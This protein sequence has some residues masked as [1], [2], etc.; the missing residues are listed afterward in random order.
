ML[1]ETEK[2]PKYSTILVAVLIVIDIFFSVVYA[3]NTLTEFLGVIG[4]VALVI[5]SVLFACL[6]ILT[7]SL[8]IFFMFVPSFAIPLSISGEMTIAFIGL[9]YIPLGFMLS[10]GIRQ[11][12]SRS[13]ILVRLSSII[14]IFYIILLFFMFVFSMGNFS[15]NNIKEIID[16]ETTEFIDYYNEVVSLYEISEQ[17]APM[18]ETERNA[19]IESLKAIIPSIIIIYV[20]IISFFATS[21]FRILYNAFVVKVQF[22]RAVIKRDKIQKEDWKI[23]MSLIST[24]VFIV[25]ILF[26]MFSSNNIWIIIA[27][28]NIIYILTPGLFIVGFYFIHGKIKLL[29]KNSN[30]AV[31]LIFFFIAILSLLFNSLI[32]MTFI[33]CGV[34]SIQIVEFKKITEK[35]KKSFDDDDFDDFDD[36][37]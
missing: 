5:A 6:I 13:Q 29:C 31:V 16:R 22:G 11:K 24:I 37:E 7:R 33:F 9:L 2:Y 32:I 10:L 36:D 28:S 19:Y 30:I 17:V 14:I 25:C 23:T 26:V 15:L 21:V 12:L 35:I 20:N 1:E 34:Y 3:V 8:Y 18:N 27:V 4:I